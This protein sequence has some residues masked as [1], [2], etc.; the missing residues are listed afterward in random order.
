M[1]TTTTQLVILHALRMAGMSMVMMPVS[2]NGLNQLPKRL[3]PH[4]TAMNNTMN[5][6]AAAIGTGFLITVMTTRT[7]V[8]TARM[9]AELGATPTEAVRQQI[10]MKA[11]LGGINDTFL[12]ASGLTILALVLAFF[13]KRAKQEE[14][15][16]AKLAKKEMKL[17]ESY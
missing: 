7:E 17:K 6:I 2:T 4:G 12:L 10:A 16:D 3:Y 13:I 11:M 14:T 1:E 8:Y 5:Q 9:I 15:D